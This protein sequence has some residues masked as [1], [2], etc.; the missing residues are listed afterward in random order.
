MW[1]ED[2]GVCAAGAHVQAWEG[3][4]TSGRLDPLQF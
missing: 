1:V 4:G 3:G 2:V